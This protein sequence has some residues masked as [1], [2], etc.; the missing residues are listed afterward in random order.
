MKKIIPFLLVAV[1]TACGQ[2]DGPQKSAGS[3]A[4]IPTVE[5]LA[6]NP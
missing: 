5:E 2:S 6:A 3:A 4:N 1:L